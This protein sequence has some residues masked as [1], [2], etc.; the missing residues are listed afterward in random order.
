[1]KE[2]QEKIV[3]A[4]EYDPQKAIS[5]SGE[6]LPELT[7]ESEE[8][9]EEEPETEIEE[10][11]DE[12]ETPPTPPPKKKKFMFNIDKGINEDDKSLLNEKGYD[13]PSE[14]EKKKKK[15]LGP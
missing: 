15:N 1:M 8:E 12:E 10:E 11:E 3:Q 14:I 7:F 4:L 6:T 9:G 13:L 5:Y 2:N